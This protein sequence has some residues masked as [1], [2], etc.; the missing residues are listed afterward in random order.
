MQKHEILDRIST[1]ADLKKLDAVSL[2]R[3]CGEIREEI[4][5][6]VSRNGG[7]LAPN[8]GVVDLTVPWK[9]PSRS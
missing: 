8:L 3:L 9:M 7:H 1:P 4:V 5:E 6:T 2:D